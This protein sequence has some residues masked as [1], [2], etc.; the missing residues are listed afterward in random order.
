M[1]NTSTTPAIVG[2]Q[3]ETVERYVEAD[4]RLVERLGVSPG[5]EFL[6]SLAVESADPVE[7]MEDFMGIIVQEVRQ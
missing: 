1:S 4:R 7:L 2:V 6:M 5:P 3:P